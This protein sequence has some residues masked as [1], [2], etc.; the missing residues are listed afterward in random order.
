MENIDKLID[1]VNANLNEKLKQLEIL[2][3]EKKVIIEQ[4]NKTKS[5]ERLLI[6]IEM[7]KSVEKFKKLSEE[8]LMLSEKVKKL[9][10]SE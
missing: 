7:K 10:E 5:S 4:Y 3:Y 8:V 1:K 2:E 6:E 9:K